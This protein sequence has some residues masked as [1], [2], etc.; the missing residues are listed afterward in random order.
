MRRRTC[1]SCNAPSEKTGETSRGEA[2]DD[3]PGLGRI[4]IQV[5]DGCVADIQECEF[6]NAVCSLR[7]DERAR[8]TSQIFLRNSSMDRNVWFGGRR[9]VRNRNDPEDLVGDSTW[10]S[11]NQEDRSN[12]YQYTDISYNYM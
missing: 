12:V 3:V 7:I 2:E 9:P 6:E 4:G 1:S 10:S 8:Y 5:G 11:E